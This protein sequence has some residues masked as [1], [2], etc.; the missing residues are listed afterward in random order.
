[1]TGTGCVS[2]APAYR[3]VALW[4]VAS[5][6][7]LVGCVAA[8]GSVT[9]ERPLAANEVA[10]TGP[11]YQA[12]V[13]GW[14]RT[15]DDPQLDR[16]IA[17]ALARNP[18]LAAALARVRSAREQATVAGTADSPQVALDAAES[19]TRVSENYVFPPPYGGATFW[20]GRLGL[21][22][23]WH[24]DFWGR[25]AALVEQA[26][27]SADAAALDATAAQ[28]LLS[29][30]VAQ[31]YVEYVRALALEQVA[32]RAAAQRGSLVQLTARRVSAG[33][34]SQVEAQTAESTFE[35]TAVDIEQSRLA[36]ATARHVLA[37]LTGTSAAAPLALD[38]PNLD[39]EQALALPHELPA[40]LL[41]RRPDVQAATL[42]VQ[43]ALAGREV[44][45]TNF[46][47]NVDLI[48]FAGFAAI[49]LDDLLHAGSRQW[50][51]GP[52]IHLPIFTAGRLQAEYRRAGAD[53]DVAIASY[54]DTVLRAVREATEQVTRLESLDTQLAP[55]ARALAAAESAYSLATQRYDA[56]IASQV[57]VLNSETQVLAARRQRT[58]LL[59]DRAAARVALLVALG[60][61]YLQEPS[62]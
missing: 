44:A 61:H 40:D 33:L 27:R 50:S 32:L 31:A 3:R 2:A 5:T 8:P 21:N 52:A 6:A 39:L 20:D 42:R 53:V 30:A 18:G 57:T 1:V 56:G 23:G 15:L 16:L 24:L 43:A 11:A 29:S 35:Q 46:Y 13:D 62:R 51:V 47:P 58:Q 37:A 17:S 28:L 19:R 48:G 49:G 38:A 9:R 36:Q 26:S 22:L 4:V 25:Q 59:A 60:G 10:L 41:A 55:Q 12:P 14:W 45:H 34:D 7:V 54:N